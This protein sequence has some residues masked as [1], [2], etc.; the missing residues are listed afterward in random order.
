VRSAGNASTIKKT[1]V[2]LLE[3]AQRV[4]GYVRVST[5]A[6]ADS[7]AGLEAQRMAIRDECH[8][9]GWMLVKLCEDEAA[10]ARSLR[11]RP[12]LEEA[13]R[14]V[15]DRSASALVVA[16]LDRLSR[17]LLDFVSLM[18]RSRRKGWSLVALDVGF[19]TTTPSGEVMAAVLAAFGQYERRLIGQRTREALAIKRREGVRLGQP[20]VV[21]AA[22][23]ARVRRLRSGGLSFASVAARLNRAA[24]T[25]RTRRP[26]ASRVSSLAF[27][28]ARARSSA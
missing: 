8:R 7:G 12:G 17:S 15:E 26:L 4:V 1:P 6:Q 21:P 9:R 18:D 14:L 25:D 19:D 16:K 3:A 27:A 23:V 24:S 13:L 22:T 28:L 20:R 5:D 2:T 10:S 11:N